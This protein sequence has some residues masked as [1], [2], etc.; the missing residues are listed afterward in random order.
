MGGHN[1]KTPHIITY[2]EHSSGIMPEERPSLK[3][4]EDDLLKG[5]LDVIAA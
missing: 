1:S 3:Y 5:I 4:V 2:I